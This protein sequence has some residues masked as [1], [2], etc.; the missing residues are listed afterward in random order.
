[1][2][3]ANLKMCQ[4]CAVAKPTDEFYRNAYAPDGLHTY[5]KVCQKAYVAGRRKTD[6]GKAINRKAQSKWRA[7]Q[8]N[9]DG[10]YNVKTQPMRVP[11][12]HTPDAFRSANKSD[13]KCAQCRKSRHYREFY[14]PDA[15]RCK[16]CE[17]AVKNEL[18]RKTPRRRGS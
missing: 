15:K 2:A 10:S 8:R 9:P 7:A 12:Q 5:C 14:G 11:S 6:E 16:E 18:D 13:R 17:L 4:R 1:M 3:Q